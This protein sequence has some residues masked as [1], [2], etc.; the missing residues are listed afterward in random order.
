MKEFLSRLLARPWVAVEL[1]VASLVVS[2]LA[3][4]SSIFTILVLNR[5]VGHGVD[6]TL[7]TLTGGVI[8]AIALEFGFRH[9][10]L[11]LARAVSLPKDKALM[12]GT[13]GVLLGARA[14][15]IDGLPQGLRREIMIGNQTG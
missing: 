11:Q 1:V 7:A 9:A 5:Y 15:A 4:A 6:T 12:E 10:R 2:V 14:S 13:F 8:I 3:L